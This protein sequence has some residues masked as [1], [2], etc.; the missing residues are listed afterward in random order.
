MR[1]KRDVIRMHVQS[2]I[3]DLDKI[4]TSYNEFKKGGYI[5]NKNTEEMNYMSPLQQ[6]PKIIDYSFAPEK[7]NLTNKP[8]TEN[9]YYAQRL[10]DMP[11]SEYTK[12]RILE[13]SRNGY[14][15]DSARLGRRIDINNLA[16]NPSYNVDNRKDKT[17]D[18]GSFYNPITNTIYGPDHLAEEAHGY[19]NK[20]EGSEILAALSSYIKKPFITLSGMKENYNI[21]GQFEYDTHKIVQPILEEYINW[22]F[23]IDSIPVKIKNK[24]NQLIK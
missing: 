20:N 6:K 16:G 5:H 10:N 13:E 4:R 23:P 7:Y 22:G 15:L 9:K 21:P 17:I 12:Q 24:R 11:V 14:Y 1:D 18:S 19:R 8:K 3:C 2:G